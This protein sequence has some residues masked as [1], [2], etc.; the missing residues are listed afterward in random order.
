VKEQMIFCPFC[1]NTN[2][3]EFAIYSQLRNPHSDLVVYNAC[4]SCG[5][6]GPDADTRKEAVEEWNK[7]PEVKQ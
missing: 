7:R 2:K 1:G 5:A 3:D 6:T 4:C